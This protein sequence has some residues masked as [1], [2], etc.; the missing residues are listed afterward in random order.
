[1][2]ENI[3]CGSFIVLLYISLAEKELCER[4]KSAICGYIFAVEAAVCYYDDKIGS[5][6]F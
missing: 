5:Y 2:C 1:M 3:F 6:Y 4:L